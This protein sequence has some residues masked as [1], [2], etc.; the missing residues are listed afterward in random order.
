MEEDNQCTGISN[1]VED[2]PADFLLLSIVNVGV[3]QRSCREALSSDV[4]KKD[5]LCESLAA[6]TVMLKAKVVSH[7]HQLS[8]A[9]LN[10]EPQKRGRSR[11]SSTRV[12]S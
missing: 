9:P 11:K 4:R 3:T 7:L 10:L 12:A 6:Q 5:G 2:A 8:P 1:G